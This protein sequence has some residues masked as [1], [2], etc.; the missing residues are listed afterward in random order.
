MLSWPFRMR[1]I[2]SCFIL[3]TGTQVIQAQNDAAD[4][5][6]QIDILRRELEAQK[7]INEQLRR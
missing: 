5:A 2:L 1:V 4:P 7:A 3:F 6:A